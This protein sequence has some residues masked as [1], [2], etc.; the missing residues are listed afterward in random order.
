MIELLYIYFAIN[1]FIAGYTLANFNFFWCVFMLLFGLPVV[2]IW[3]LALI[4]KIIMS[5]LQLGFWF[6]WI[7]LRKPYKMSE[8]T[9]IELNMHVNSGSKNWL[10]NKI[11]RYGVSL[12]N[13]RNNFV[14]KETN[15]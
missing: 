9:L 14:Y 15:K 2:L 13:K 11:Y 4:V 12:I 10:G 1:G 3:N 8:D 6:D 7:V 5:T